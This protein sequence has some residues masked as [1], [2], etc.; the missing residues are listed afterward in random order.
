MSLQNVAEEMKWSRKEMSQE[1]DTLKRQLK[2]LLDQGMG[3]ARRTAVL[4][5][6]TERR[7]EDR[8]AQLDSFQ[9][10][11]EKAAVRF[12]KGSNGAPQV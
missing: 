5:R 9:T 3:E 1:L 2:E 10:E 8:F 6:N 12:R 7:V 4:L 11:R